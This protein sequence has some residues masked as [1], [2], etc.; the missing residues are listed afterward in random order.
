MA[1]SKEQHRLIDHLLEDLNI[2][3]DAELAR[4]MKLYPAVISKIRHGTLAVGASFI[5]NVHETFG[6]PVKDI[7]A[8]ING[9]Q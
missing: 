9:G 1:R 6:I 8:I 2:P 5:L 3:S 4:R 7:K